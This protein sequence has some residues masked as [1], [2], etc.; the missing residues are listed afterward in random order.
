MKQTILLFIFHIYLKHRIS[1]E[2]CIFFYT[3]LG[4]ELSGSSMFSGRP[5]ET[6][7]QS[8]TSPQT[9]MLDVCESHY[10]ANPQHSLLTWWGGGFFGRLYLYMRSFLFLVDSLCCQSP[11]GRPAGSVTSLQCI[12]GELK[13]NRLCGSFMLIQF[14]VIYNLIVWVI[15]VIYQWIYI[16]LII[17]LLHCFYLPCITLVYTTGLSADW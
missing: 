8:S 1:C 9:L 13:W 17:L 6:E 5:T 4:S 10:S 14:L 15:D 7:V 12:G 3:F 11:D 2:I 16:I